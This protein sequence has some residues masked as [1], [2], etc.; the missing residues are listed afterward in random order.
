M[1]FLVCTALALAQCHSASVTLSNT[2]LPRDTSGSLLLT[3]E[4]SILSYNGTFYFYFNNWGGCAGVDCCPSSS[5][6]A[7]CCF[8]GPSDPCVYT[9]NHSVVAYSTTD[10]LSWTPLGEVL[11]VDARRAGIEFR[12]QVV[13]C[14]AT[15]LFLMYYEDRWSSGSNPGYAL[16]ASPTPWG[17][18]ATVDP[19]VVMGGRGRVGDFDVFVDTVSTPHTAYHIR[20]GLSIQR[21]SANFS[22]PE[23]KAVDI[24]NGGVEGPAMF[25][26]AGVYYLLAGLGCCACRGGSNVVVY[27]APSPLG[28]FKLQGDVGSN[29][30]QAF[31]AH[32]PTNY[33]THAQQTKV[34]K[35]AAADGST[36]YLWVGNQ[37]VS[38]SAGPAGQWGPRNH[39]LLYF[40]LLQFDSHGRILQLE[41]SPT[42]T[43]SLPAGGK[44]K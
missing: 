11:G 19:S 30:S 5:G 14:E 13:F 22:A 6:C 35:V 3:G 27:T 41:Y 25:E 36:Q 17:P 34:I 44:E 43:L 33:V 20:T 31:D 10:F 7:S 9:T 23:G 26:R 12:P 42:C 2:A 39:D 32:S 21:L 24:P 4:A 16:A 29:R 40:A 1:L 15:S 38:N 8:K 37:W 18:F 28:P